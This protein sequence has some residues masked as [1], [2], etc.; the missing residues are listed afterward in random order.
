VIDGN[1]TLG[2]STWEQGLRPV[3]ETLSERRLGELLGE[4]QNRI[5]AIV[6]STR[7]RMDALLKSVLA[8]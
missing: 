1:A 4:V 7:D 3:G 6:G 5:Q 8:V 2:S